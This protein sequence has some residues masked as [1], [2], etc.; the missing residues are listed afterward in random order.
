MKTQGWIIALLTLTGVLFCEASFAQQIHTITLFVNTAEV[1][2]QNTSQTCTFGQAGGVTNEDFTIQAR[3]GDIIIWKGVS[4]NAP[5]TDIV[6]ITAINY[7]GGANIFDKNVLRGNGQEPE[8]VIGMIVQ[9]TPG[10]EEK[11]T[12]SFKVLNNGSKRNGAFHIDP[13]IK[14]NP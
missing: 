3:N 10:D 6:N 7:Q 9:G 5:E 8:V 12:V 14:I 4:S 1:T 13:K 2:A 11:Y